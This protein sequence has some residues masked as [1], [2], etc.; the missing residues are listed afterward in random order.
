MKHPVFTDSLDQ[1]GPES[2]VA[3]ADSVITAPT[4]NPLE[5]LARS[6]LILSSSH[7]QPR[8]KSGSWIFPLWTSFS[9]A[10]SEREKVVNIRVVLFSETPANRTVVKTDVAS[11]LLFVTGTIAPL[12]R[13]CAGIRPP[14]AYPAASELS[15]RTRS[16]VDTTCFCMPSFL[17]SM[18]M[19]R[20]SNCGRWMIGKSAESPRLFFRALG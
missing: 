17:W 8:W 15:W 11:D 3:P 13:I 12:A 14:P 6:P 7:T 1:A 16:L 10:L 9:K 5:M 4:G 19:A 2:D 20:P 18:P